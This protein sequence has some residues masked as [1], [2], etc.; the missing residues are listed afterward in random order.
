M[1]VI[2][3]TAAKAQTLPAATPVPE[4]AKSV[5]SVVSALYQVISGPA[6]EQ[7]N[8]DRMRALFAP[9]AIMTSVGRRSDG[10]SGHRTISV[11]E[12]IKLSEPLM[13]K[14]G[15]FEKETARKSQTFG[16]IVQVFT[17]YET[18]H[19]LTDKQV[20]MR[21]INGIQLVHSR[22]RWWILSIFWEDEGNGLTIPK[23]FSSGK[24]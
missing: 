13:M 8:W 4:D 1:A 20:W 5:D 2:A 24:H 14:E 9:G 11:E 17:T 12:Y 10:R 23:E 3:L 19:N 21:G 6:G 16:D 22:G 7:R 15:F 18:K